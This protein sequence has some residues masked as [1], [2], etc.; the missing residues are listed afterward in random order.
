MSLPHASSE[1]PMTVVMSSSVHA[2]KAEQFEESLAECWSEPEIVDTFP[3]DGFHPAPG[4]D[5]M[6]A[7]EKLI[8]DYL[9]A[10]GV[11]IDDNPVI[12]ED[13]DFLAATNP[14]LADVFVQILSLWDRATAEGFSDELPDDKSLCFVVLGYKLNPDGSMDDELVSRLTVALEYADKYPNA[15]IIVSGGNPVNGISEA[16]AMYNWLISAGIEADRIYVEE[17]S[18]TTIDNVYYSYHILRALMVRHIAVI[19]SGYHLQA[20]TQLFQEHCLIQ[21]GLNVAASIPSPSKLI[22]GFSAATRASW[23]ISLTQK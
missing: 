17:M 20:A 11:T 19:T 12:W 4:P 13:V 2:T 1:E 23:I 9:S 3:Q 7:L 8:G 21:G 16:R 6:P 10:D 18:R 15:Y 5:D 22:E 14:E